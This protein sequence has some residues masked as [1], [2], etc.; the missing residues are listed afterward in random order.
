[1]LTF[2]A[3]LS[4]TV[5]KLRVKAVRACG[6]DLVKP[7]QTHKHHVHIDPA[8]FLKRSSHQQL[9]FLWRVWQA[10]LHTTAAFVCDLEFGEWFLRLP[11][12]LLL[13]YQSQ[14]SAFFTSLIHHGEHPVFSL[15][16]VRVTLMLSDDIAQTFPISQ[17]IKNLKTL[18]NLLASSSA[19][20][21]PRWSRC[22]ALCAV[23]NDVH[24]KN[25]FQSELK[26]KVQTLLCSSEA[27]ATAAFMVTTVPR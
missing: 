27:T 6:C 1:M 20:C 11:W 26:P 17:L 4:S 3:F 15:V 2:S 5:S 9:Q 13:L 23:W 19:L 8:T 12:L 7:P 22:S 24:Y 21:S 16:L 25:T 14:L 18:G 10:V